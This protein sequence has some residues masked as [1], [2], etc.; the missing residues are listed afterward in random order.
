MFTK[1]ILY[2]FLAGAVY[3]DLRK[4]KIYNL[5]VI[6]FLLAGVITSALEGPMGLCNSLLAVIAS[7][8]VLL[9][10]YLL[11]GIAAGD[12][13]LIMATASFLSFQ[14]LYSCILFS[15]LFAGAIS[16]LIIIF[17][18]NRQRTIHFALPVMAGT[19]FTLGGF[20]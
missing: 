15:F 1:P 19:L 2:L 11:K 17:K 4:D 20:L 13:K 12:I 9:P 14:E 18:R 8:L 16:L 7:L 10:V 3:T 5:W 6:P